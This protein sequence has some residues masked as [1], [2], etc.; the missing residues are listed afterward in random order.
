MPRPVAPN[1]DILHNYGT[2]AKTENQ[3]LYITI[4]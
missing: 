2:F 4:K 3:L 1:V